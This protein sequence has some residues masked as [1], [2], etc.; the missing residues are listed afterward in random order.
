MRGPGAR[1]TSRW[2][3][4]GQ[5]PTASLEKRLL[6]SVKEGSKFSVKVL[7]LHGCEPTDSQMWELGTDWDF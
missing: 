3:N 2:T 5:P 6:I 7:S 4:L 1:R